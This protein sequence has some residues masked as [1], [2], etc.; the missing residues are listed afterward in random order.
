MCLCFFLYKGLRS[1]FIFV[2]IF[3]DRSALKKYNFHFY[4]HSVFLVRLYRKWLRGK[5]VRNKQPLF[6]FDMVEFIAKKLNFKNK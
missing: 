2:C 4:S 3:D 5:K 1:Q 6:S